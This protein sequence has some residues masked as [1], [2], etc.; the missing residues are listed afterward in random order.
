MQ[1][2]PER[3]RI[4]MLN[5]DTM[6]PAEIQRRREVFLRV[7]AASLMTATLKLASKP[8]NA[9]LFR[10]SP[11]AVCFNLNAGNDDAGS[12]GNQMWARVFSRKDIG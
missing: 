2:Y 10:V 1:I 9:D 8:E 6:T 5:F 12:A 7:N 4:L 3:S 11:G